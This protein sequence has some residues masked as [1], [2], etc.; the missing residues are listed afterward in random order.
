MLNRRTLSKR[1]GAA[2]VFP[3]RRRDG[4]H[5]YS[6]LKFDNPR[7][8]RG[9]IAKYESPVGQPNEVYLPPG[10][11]EVLEQPN[12]ELLITEGE[13]KALK[14]M[15]EGFP[16]I[17]LVGVYG[18]KDAKSERLLPALENIPFLGRRVY[19]CLD[20]DA[21]D[22]PNV[23][24]A[25]SR[26]A[27][28][29]TNLGAVVRVVRL[30]AGTVGADGKPAKVGLDDFLVA[31]TPAELRQLL[32]TAVEPEELH[33]PD[34]KEKANKIEPS[35]FASSFLAEDE[36]DE[37]PHR[38]YWRGG[39][40]LWHDGR[41]IEIETSEVQADLVRSINRN[42]VYLTTGVIGNVLAQVKAQSALPSRTEPPTWLGSAAVEWPSSEVLATRRELIHMPSLVSDKTYSMPATPRFFSTSALDYEFAIDAPEPKC[43]LNFLRE[44]W[45]DDHESISTL[46]EICGYLLTLDTRQQK[47][48]MLI[49]PPRSGK[50]TIARLLGRLVGP[51]NVAAPTLASLETNFGLAPLLG[52]SVAIIADARLSARV[53]QSKVVERMLSISGED[54]LTADR[55][56]REPVT[57]KIPARLVVI[58]NEL[59]RLAESSG[60]L[61]NRMIVLRLTKSFLGRE[62]TDL[63]EKLLVELPGILL[64]AIEGW[65]RLR[66]RGKFVQP[67]SGRELAD[68]MKD[69]SSPTGMFLREHCKIGPEFNASVDLVYAAWRDWCM[70]NGH[71]HPGTKQTFGRNL[72]AAVPSLRDSQPREDGVRYRRYEGLCL[73]E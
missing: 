60:A 33:G 55:K 14:A 29:L 72:R 63:T 62:D 12:I 43:W 19:I 16:C 7:T 22:N 57:G 56:Y 65:R 15:Q 69:L 61:A 13:K 48:F 32:D 47:I 17:G 40:F 9:K 67:Q 11:A 2:I 30:P 3:F 31:H 24:E 25:E 5:G 39:F 50:G 36:S 66:E 52:K 46:Q 73:L 4:S 23:R 28:Q 64:W 49:G 38:R 53:D 10:V 59:P 20:S 42:Y 71:D 8:I 68:E 70:D 44:L 1:M 35:S 18:W 34:E 6:R 21:A 45:G 37:M 51:A 27:K 54:S 41:Y 58:S 26:L